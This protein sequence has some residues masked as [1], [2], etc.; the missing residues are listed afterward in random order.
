MRVA[1]TTTCPQFK[2]HLA[3]MLGHWQYDVDTW[4]DP[5]ASAY[6]A[7]PQRESYWCRINDLHPGQPVLDSPVPGDPSICEVAFHFDRFMPGEPVRAGDIDAGD[8]IH[9]LGPTDTPGKVTKVRVQNGTVTIA[10][11]FA[12]I[13]NEFMAT[14]DSE[15]GVRRVMEADDA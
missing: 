15:M 10:I 1:P 12:S 4:I 5:V 14:L 6:E 2:A 13:E 9:W 3:K 7:G 8:F 11:A